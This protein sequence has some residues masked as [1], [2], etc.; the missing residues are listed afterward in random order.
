M[1]LEWWHWAGAAALVGV[2]AY[3]KGPKMV[4]IIKGGRQQYALLLTL[5]NKWGPIFGAPASTI[6]TISKIESDWRPNLKNTNERAMVRGGAWGAMQQT[7]ETAKGHATALKNHSN[8]L[9][10]A[11][12]ARW[13]GTGPGLLNPDIN[14]MFG[15]YQL[16]KLTKEFKEF[17]LVAAAYHQGAAKVR[18]MLAAKKPIPAELPPFGKQYVTKALT[19]HKELFA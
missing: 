2:A 4:M 5:A 3:Y 10:R 8:S 13:D 11:T 17:G 6:M 14:V 9:V 15:A 7:L 16:G 1:R 19:T 18:S 12:L